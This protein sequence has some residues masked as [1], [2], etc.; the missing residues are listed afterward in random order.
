MA[1]YPDWSRL[2]Q[3]IGSDIKVP[4]DVQGQF[5]TLDINILSTT[6]DIDVNINAAAIELDIDITAQH[7]GVY[8]V[9]D[10]SAKEG[11]D[12]TFSVSHTGG[13]GTGDKGSYN[14][15]AGKT[16][17]L[18]AFTW[19][20]YAANA[21]DADKPH[22]SMVYLRDT[23]AGVNYALHGGDGGGGIALNKPVVIPENHTLQYWATVRANHNCSVAFCVLG[24]EI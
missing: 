18:T 20:C 19:Y 24:Y 23:T 5:I 16:L 10:W 7:I 14:V 3:L 2:V 12:K 13:H 17:Y 8:L 6:A 21:A 15:P 11:D 1:D 4:I 22:H 9:P